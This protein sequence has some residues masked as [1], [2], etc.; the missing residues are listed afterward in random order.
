MRAIRIVTLVVAVGLALGACAQQQSAPK[1]TVGTLGGAAAG[2][3]LGAQFGS[4]TGQLIG[5]ALGALG[6]AFLGSEIGKSMDTVDRQE[7]AKTQQTALEY[8]KTGQSATWSN[9]D[10]GARGTVTPV[11]T[12]QSNQG[13][14]CREYRHD[15]KVGDK[16]E[17][18]IGQACRQSDG[19]WKVVSEG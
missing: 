6:G 5:V 13:Q 14:A 3:L 4:G 7:A 2:G 8:N 10:T 15:V 11:R 17:Q 12:F 18:V 19:T 1:Q 9:P 16:T